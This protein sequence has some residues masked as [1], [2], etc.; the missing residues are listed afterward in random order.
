MLKFA[1]ILCVLS[2]ASCNPPCN[3]SVGVK[4]GVV[5]SKTILGDPSAEIYEDSWLPAD[6]RK[7]MLEDLFEKVL[8][9]MY[10]EFKD[11]IISRKELEEMAA[12]EAQLR[13]EDL[14]Q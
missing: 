13:F 1:V 2:F 9:E 8:A 11:V 10:I 14:C 12:F 5:E 4:L 3:T 6:T 7:Q